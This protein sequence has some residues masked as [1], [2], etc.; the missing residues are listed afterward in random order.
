MLRVIIG[1]FLVLHGLVHLLYFGQSARFFELQPEI[2]W[3][4]G[5]WVFSKFLA[6]AA[7]RWL[8]GISCI[9]AALGFVIG[10]AGILAGLTWWRPVVVVS[11]AFSALIFILFWNGKL[12][13]LD[14]QGAIA[15]LI[16]A[17][18]LIA[19]LAFRWPASGF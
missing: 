11:A 6:E 12:Q 10:G 19:V 7:T 5:S 14:N 17:A 16:N 2:A 15:I 8:A 1:V 13:K 4:D 9:L 18:I 3:P